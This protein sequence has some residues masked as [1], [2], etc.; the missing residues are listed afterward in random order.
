MIFMR[1][2]KVITK[3]ITIQITTF[4]QRI[5]TITCGVVDSYTLYNNARAYYARAYKDSSACLVVR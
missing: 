3:V 5:A 2:T 1:I 4:Y